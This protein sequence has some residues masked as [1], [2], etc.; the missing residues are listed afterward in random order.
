MTGGDIP[1]SAKKTF[2]SSS[3]ENDGIQTLDST[4]T[5]EEV[6]MDWFIYSNKFIKESCKLL[7]V[8]FASLESCNY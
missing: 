3:F 7:S 6:I 2:N 4:A 5:I 1:K 8:A